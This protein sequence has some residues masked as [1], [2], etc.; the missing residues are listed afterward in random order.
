MIGLCDMRSFYCSCEKV[1]RPDIRD[2]GVVVTSNNDGVVVALDD[3]AKAAGIKKFE[4][5][6]KQR[7]HHAVIIGGNHHTSIANIRT[8]HLLTGTVK[9]AHVTQTYHRLTPLPAPFK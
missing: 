5:Y 3:R 1:F 6:F 2:R 9:A 4:P 8:K 7:H